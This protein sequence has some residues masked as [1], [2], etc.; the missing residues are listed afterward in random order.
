ML[1]ILL[2]SINLLFF[3]SCFYHTVCFDLASEATS[4]VLLQPLFNFHV[5]LIPKMNGLHLAFQ[6]LLLLAPHSLL[7]TLI[8]QLWALLYGCTVTAVAAALHP[9]FPMQTALLK[10]AAYQ[11][12]HS[13]HLQ[14]M[15]WG[16]GSEEP[17]G[18]VILTKLSTSL[19]ITQGSSFLEELQWGQTYWI[20]GGQ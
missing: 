5:F 16:E 6:M 7:S 18:K 4:I 20:L 9:T 8:L 15:Q 12:A 2:R 3:L 19:L 10:A 1:T 13:K 14:G 11:K 17:S